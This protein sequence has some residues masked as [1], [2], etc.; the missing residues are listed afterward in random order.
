[1]AVG[2]LLVKPLVPPVVVVSLAFERGL[3][4]HPVVMV[5]DRLRVAALF[6]GVLG[7]AKSDAC[8][9]S[10]AMIACLLASDDAE[11]TYD[12]LTVCRRGG[13]CA[14]ERLVCL[15]VVFVFFEL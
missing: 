9:C 5:N 15:P 4:S 8:S 12:L 11:T 2:D 7:D 13:V 3:F 14:V 10:A 1:M 6:S